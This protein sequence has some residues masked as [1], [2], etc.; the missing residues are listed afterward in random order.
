M[1]SAVARPVLEVLFSRGIPDAE[2]WEA[3]NETSP[4]R[5]HRRGSEA[6]GIPANRF[7]L[8]RYRDMIESGVVCRQERQIVQSQLN[9]RGFLRAPWK[10][11]LSLRVRIP[12]GNCRS[13]R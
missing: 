12:P 9:L 2:A 4:Q 13:S 10:G 3:M 6:L 8:S 7:R 1:V 11:A 5:M